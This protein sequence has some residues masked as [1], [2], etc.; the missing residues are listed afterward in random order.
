MSVNF[1]V[2]TKLLEIS[3]TDNVAV[4]I[5]S[6]QQSFLLLIT[7]YAIGKLTVPSP[8]VYVMDC[9]VVSVGFE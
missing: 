3:Y 6:L 8:I 9:V 7:I 5:L 4:L 2:Y 1:L